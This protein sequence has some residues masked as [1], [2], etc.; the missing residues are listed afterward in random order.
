MTGAMTGAMIEAL[1]DAHADRYAPCGMSLPE[2]PQKTE[3]IARMGKGGFSLDR[4]LWWRTHGLAPRP[5]SRWRN[6]SP[7]YVG[8]TILKHR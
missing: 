7:W 3:E 8:C 1:I 2:P 6:P 5:I 4:P